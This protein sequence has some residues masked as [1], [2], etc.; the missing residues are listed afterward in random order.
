LIGEQLP[1][2]VAVLLFV[3]VN[4][5]CRSIRA[6]VIK[7]HLERC[8]TAVRMELRNI[9]PSGVLCDDGVSGHLIFFAER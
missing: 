2:F 7:P 5:S 4:V 9:S 3:L 1:Q 6:G 8:V